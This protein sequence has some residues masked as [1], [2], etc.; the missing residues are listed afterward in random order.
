M[1]FETGC[2]LD[3]NDNSVCDR[4]E[5]MEAELGGGGVVCGNEACEEGETSASCCRDCGCAPGYSCNESGVCEKNPGLN[6]TF[7]PGFKINLSAISFCGD[8]SCS[9]G[10]TQ[11]SCCR[12]CGCPVLQSCENNT[13]KS[14]M[15]L[16]SP[17][18]FAPLVTS[19]TSYIVV[20]L[21][22]VKVLHNGDGTGEVGE[23]MLAAETSSGASRQR[24]KWPMHVWHEVRDSQVIL[25]GDRNAV[26]LFA[27]TESSMGDDL[28][29]RLWAADSDYD[30]SALSFKCGDYGFLDSD[31]ASEDIGPQMTCGDNDLL[32]DI[33]V[34]HGRAEDWGVSNST[35]ETS[36]GDVIVR[37]S[38]KRVFVPD[39][40]PVEVTLKKVTVQ[41]DGDSGSNPGEI[42]VFTRVA[43]GF[44]RYAFGMD[45]GDT[46]HQERYLAGGAEYKMNDGESRV[47]NERIFKTCS[48]GPFLYIEVNVLD[49]DG[50]CRAGTNYLCEFQ[51]LG[52]VAQTWLAYEE[53]LA[54]TKGGTVTLDINEERATSAGHVTVELE[55][56]RKPY[57]HSG[58]VENDFMGG[59]P[60]GA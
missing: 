45:Y 15:K 23:L 9:S 30:M 13:C 48:L 55:V 34:S 35:H 3:A 14:S 43:D 59:G 32:G 20:L 7:M 57:P 53:L 21:E 19:G 16:I 37:Y 17:V 31:I 4:D 18:V 25:G 10:E 29:V 26:P 58:C 51:E 8:G 39:K 54:K 6:L 24:L 47:F 11:A 49:R 38:V 33:V 60:S 42:N 22:E 56:S 5:A 28:T 40:M 36:I 44:E 50:D 1:Y 27:A 46:A 52:T 2:C 12:D 41:Q